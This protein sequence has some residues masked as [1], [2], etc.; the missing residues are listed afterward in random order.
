L[1]AVNPELSRR[2]EPLDEQGQWQQHYQTHFRTVHH[3]VRR[4]VGS[5]LLANSE[6]LTQEAFAIAY[7]N[8]HHFG[9][10]S[11]LNTWICGI[12]LNLVR[13]HV[14]RE[15]LASRVTKMFSDAAFIPQS[16]ITDDPLLLQVQRERAIEILS[17]VDSLPE[18]LLRAFAACCIF[19]VSQE[20]AAA[21]LGIS[22]GN[23]RVRIT[24]AKALIRH[25]ISRRVA[26]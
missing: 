15:A 26:G 1:K 2:V 20:E 17:V 8:R 22:E 10:R 24:R 9:G 5:D 3:Y 16:A 18:K 11:S 12:A 7:A 4:L 19:G 21:Q 6:D 13:Q 14:A 25:R 23:L